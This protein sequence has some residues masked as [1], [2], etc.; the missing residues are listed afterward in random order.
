MRVDCGIEFGLFTGNEVIPT[1]GLSPLIYMTRGRSVISVSKAD[2]L[3]MA[4]Y[5]RGD[6]SPRQ[7]IVA[8][9]STW[10]LLVSNQH[11]SFTSKHS[12]SLIDEKRQILSVYDKCLMRTLNERALPSDCGLRQRMN[13]S[14]PSA[15]FCRAAI[16][17][18]S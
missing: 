15:W 1:I 5:S 13:E 7:S 14:K 16:L 4:T 9:P 18:F 11:A 17:V 6:S 8:R 2:S 12:L 10:H 3:C